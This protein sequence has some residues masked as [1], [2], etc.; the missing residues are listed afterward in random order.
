MCGRPLRCKREIGVRRG[1]VQ[2]CVRPVCAALNIRWLTSRAAVGRDHALKP[3]LL[4]GSIR[5][6]LSSRDVEEL[7]AERGIEASYDT[8]L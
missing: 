5:F 4:E 8:V 2:S 7:L 3:G 1:R 6:T